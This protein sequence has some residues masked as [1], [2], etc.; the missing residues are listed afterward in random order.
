[1][2]GDDEKIYNFIDKK[3]VADYPIFYKP[4]WMIWLSGRLS[5]KKLAI[6]NHLA[7][8]YFYRKSDET[9]LP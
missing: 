3:F 7:F 9:D 6:L 2:I 5:I 4:K 8:G 1:M